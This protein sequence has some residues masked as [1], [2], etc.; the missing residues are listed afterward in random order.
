M[1]RSIVVDYQGEPSSFAF[2]KIDRSKLY[3]IRRRVA[4]DPSGAACE[5]A[6]LTE[7]G[8]LILR[9]G[10]LAQAYFDRDGRWIPNSELVG[11][12]AGGEPLEQRSSTLGHT[13]PLQ[14]PVPVQEL[15]DVRAQSTYAL[16]P[17][18]LGETL[19]ARL[20]D[21][22]I[23]RLP[24]VYRTSWEE[25]WAWLVANTDGEFFAVIGT[26][27]SPLWCEPN[28]LPEVEDADDFDDELDFEMF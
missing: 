3:G 8:S 23:F 1:A 19:K 5:R 20:L 22:D 2:K 6:A 11:L 14:G 4:L 9:Q 17:E 26:Q 21:G 12:D 27:T 25:S 24:F 10:M 15:L 13:V 7:D 18:E 28:R 16:D